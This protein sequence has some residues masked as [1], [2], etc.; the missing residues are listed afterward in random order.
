[1]YCVASRSPCFWRAWT[2]PE[3]DCEIAVCAYWQGEIVGC[4]SLAGSVLKCIAVSPVLQGEGLSLKLLTEL[5][6]LAYELNRSELF[7]FTKPQNRLLFSGAGFWPIAQ[8]GELAVLMENS[9]ERLARFCRQ[10]ALY[11]Q[12]GKTIRRHRRET[13]IRLHWATVIW[14][15]KRLRPVTGCIC[16]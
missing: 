3:D 8:A 15:S 7:L 10:L 4:G 11:R 13:P 12:P 14:W 9:S 5:L 6:T 2:R 16:L 1:M